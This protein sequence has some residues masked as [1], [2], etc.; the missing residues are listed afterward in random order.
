MMKLPRKYGCCFIDAFFVCF[1]NKHSFHLVI[2]YFGTFSY[3]WPCL[4]LRCD[5]YVLC[6]TVAVQTTYISSR[7]ADGPAWTKTLNLIKMERLENPPLGPFLV[8]LRFAL[9][10]LCFF[11]IN[12]TT[13]NTSKELQAM[14][15]SE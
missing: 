7:R 4:H 1:S 9:R 13:I 2:L 15:N 11:Q 10:G 5:I 3:E 8:V 14:V 6:R 12:T